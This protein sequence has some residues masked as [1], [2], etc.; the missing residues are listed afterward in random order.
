MQNE[1]ATDGTRI[2]GKKKKLEFGDLIDRKSETKTK[3]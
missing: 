2:T 1:E 3:F